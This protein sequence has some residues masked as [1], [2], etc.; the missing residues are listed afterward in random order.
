MAPFSKGWNKKSNTKKEPEKTEAPVESTSP[1]YKAFHVEKDKGLWRL[2]ISDIQD[3]KI[4]KQ[5]ILESENRALALERFKIKFSD[6]Y[7]IG[8]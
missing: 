2:V 7:F 3:G 8:K 5:Q 4:L 6:A 1:I